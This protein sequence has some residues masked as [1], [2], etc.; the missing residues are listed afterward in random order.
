MG[1]IEEQNY[2]P[3]QGGSA[4]QTPHN[5]LTPTSGPGDKA[6]SVMGSHRRLPRHRTLPHTLFRT[7]NYV[8]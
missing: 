7:L 2:P 4:P 1:E 8:T 3:L 6:S 5:S